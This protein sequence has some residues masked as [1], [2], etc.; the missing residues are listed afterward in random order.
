MPA[1]QTP[2]PLYPGTQAD[3]YRLQIHDLSTVLYHLLPEISYNL[4]LCHLTII[5]NSLMASN[6]SYKVKQAF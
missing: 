2:L 4:Y 1:H 6:Q 5:K 3:I